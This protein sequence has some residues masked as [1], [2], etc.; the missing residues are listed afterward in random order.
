MTRKAVKVVR[1]PE[2]IKLLADPV[3]REILRQTTHQPQT[4][5]QLAEKL[6][7]S[8]PSTAHHLQALRKAGLIK[9]GRTKVGSYGIVEK[10]YEPTS[11]LFIEDFDRTPQKLRK[12]F[13]QKNIERLRGMLSVLQI[14]GERQGRGVEISRDQLKELAEDIAKYMARIGERYEQ[15]EM[16]V[17]RENL[18]IRIY[19]EAL[20]AVMAESKWRDFFANLIDLSS[21][22]RVSA[23]IT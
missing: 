23:T 12:Y 8:K 15:K 7:L 2:I 5:T 3:R 14:I 21:S 19:S 18:L 17:G 11:S 4:Q 20:M 10:Y 9:I 22:K 16:D 1:K 6:R 13:L